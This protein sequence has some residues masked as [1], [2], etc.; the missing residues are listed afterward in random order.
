MLLHK[1]DFWL[2]RGR[3]KVFQIFAVFIPYPKRINSSVNWLMGLSLIRPPRF[4]LA[5][6]NKAKIDW[7]AKVEAYGLQFKA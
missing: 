5:L 3:K 6:A 4:L 2:G 7:K 1:E